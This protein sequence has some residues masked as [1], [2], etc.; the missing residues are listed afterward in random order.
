MLLQPYERLEESIVRLLANGGERSAR[1]LHSDLCIAPF[2]K[3]CSLKAVYK[4]LGALEIQG[5][6]FKYR[7]NYSLKLTWILSLADLVD[8]MKASYSPGNVA[9]EL[10]RSGPKQRWKFSSLAQLNGFWTQVILA[11]IETSTSKLVFDWVPHPWFYLAE[12]SVER[13]FM[14]VVAAQNAAFYRI[15]GGRS[16]LD[17]EPAAYWSQLPGVTSYSPGPFDGENDTYRVVAGSFVNIVKLDAR[18]TKRLEE[19]YAP[20]ATATS[21]AVADVY[22]VMHCG[23]KI[24][25]TLE[26]NPAKAKRLTRVFC[27]YFGIREPS[28]ENSA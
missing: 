2:S 4:A 26:D 25:M 20:D 7:T 14:R 23:A 27:D 17:R 9:R 22:S 10:L 19:L 18:L 21:I 12:P 13:Q 24:S 15:V 8:K 28:D 1:E 6:V 16:A 5:V 11:M 3:R